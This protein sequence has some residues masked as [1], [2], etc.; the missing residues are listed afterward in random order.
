MDGMNLSAQTEK[1]LSL[2]FLKGI[3]SSTLRK[4]AALPDF[5]TKP[6]A[7][8]GV[9][10]TA[11][12]RALAEPDAWNKA[13]EAAERQTETARA[14]DTAILS[15]FDAAYPK[16]LSAAKDGPCVLFVTGTLPAPEQHVMAI[17]G[18]RE[19]T[20]HGAVIAARVSSHFAEQGWSVVSG[21]AIGCDAI[22]HQASMDAGG[23]TVAVMAHGL[24]TVT[25]AQNRRLAD[26]ILASGGALVSEFPFGQEA[27]PQLF[28]RRDRTQAALAE[29]VLMIQ[30]GLE[31]GSLHACR[32]A[33]AYGRWL[34]VP[35]PTERDRQNAEENIS[36]NMMLAEGPIQERA[37]LLSC[38]GDA[39]DRVVIL[40]DKRDYERLQNYALPDNRDLLT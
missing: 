2:S 31:G 32:A 35:Y 33:I 17:V 18:T 24:Q 6:V 5:A 37:A 15:P 39:L 12:A 3:G 25:P 21:L 16:L 36:A 40:R 29:G 10:V 22:A 38:A 20:S 1:L 14:H 19:P 26:N 30:S 27:L 7:E 8:L 34:A 13:I 23:H 11:L 9:H 28:A 4:L